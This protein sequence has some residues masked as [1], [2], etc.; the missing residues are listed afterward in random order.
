MVHAVKRIKRVAK[1]EHGWDFFSASRH[2][3]N[4][5]RHILCLFAGEKQGFNSATRMLFD[6]RLSEVFL[7]EET[8]QSTGSVSSRRLKSAFEPNG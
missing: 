7:S 6:G 5:H 4:H 8:E 2:R 3:S 1:L